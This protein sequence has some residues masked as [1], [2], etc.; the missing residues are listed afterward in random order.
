MVLKRKIAFID[1][2]K[3]LVKTAPVSLRPENKLVGKG[4]ESS[5]QKNQPFASIKMI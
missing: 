1:L 2:K 5:I 3:V 4:K